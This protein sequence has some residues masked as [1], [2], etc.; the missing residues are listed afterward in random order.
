MLTNVQSLFWLDTLCIPVKPEH[1]HLREWSFATMASIYAGASRVLVLD[2]E[3]MNMACPIFA[4]SLSRIMCSAWMS[5]SW[6]LQEAALSRR[7]FFQFA[8]ATVSPYQ[9]PGENSSETL[10]IVS[11][12]WQTQQPAT[13]TFDFDRNLWSA[14]R[15][16]L[17]QQLLLERNLDF[18]LHMRFITAWDA[19]IHRSTSQPN[20]IYVILANLSNIDYRP[21]LKMPQEKRLP[22]M[23]LAFKKIP[24]SLFFNTGARLGAGRH[25]NNRWMPVEL[26]DKFLSSEHLVSLKN[27]KPHLN[28]QDQSDLICAFLIQKVVPHTLKKYVIKDGPGMSYCI[29]PV[30]PANDLLDTHSMHYTIV[31]IQ[32]CEQQDMVSNL[33]GAIFYARESKRGLIST[34][35]FEPSLTAV[36]HCPITATECQEGSSSLTFNAVHFRRHRINIK[37]GTCQV[38]LCILLFAIS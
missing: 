17:Q 33:E 37:Y 5:R 9:T 3:L 11:E 22:A 38:L 7:C 15:L 24:L 6:T 25:H 36:F 35:L 21:L 13:N 19:L 26:G 31:I 4:L 28:L 12:S 34:I 20:D 32:K 8:D 14:L 16:L 18:T 1:A 29:R 30:L 27:G 2:A 10:N 23:L